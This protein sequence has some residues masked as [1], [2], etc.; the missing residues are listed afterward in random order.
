MQVPEGRVPQIGVATWTDSI[1]KGDDIL[2]IQ[3]CLVY[4]AFGEVHHTTFCY[5]YD[6]KATD[7]AHLSICLVGNY[8]N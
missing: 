4:E 2:T 5:F 3:G 6:G 7:P 1:N 8:V